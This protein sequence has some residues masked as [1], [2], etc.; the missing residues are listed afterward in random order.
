M[1]YVESSQ[2][3]QR[4]KDSKKILLNVH[5][6]PDP[7]TVG[8]ALSMYKVLKNMGKNVDIVCPNEVP[9]ELSF[10]ANAGIIKK[11]NFNKFSFEDYDLFIIMDTS[12]VERVTG[13]SDVKN[14]P[15]TTIVID[16]HKTS[17]SFGDINLMDLSTSSVCEMLYFLFMDWKIKIDK[18]IANCLYTGILGDTGIFQFQICP[19][20]FKVADALMSLDANHDK[21]VFNLV[22][23]RP[24][25]LLKGWGKILDSLQLEKDF[26][27]VWSA[28]DYNTFARLG[29]VHGIRDISATLFL[30]TVEDTNFGLVMVEEE[31]G[32]LSVSLR[33]RNNFD[34]SKIAQSLGGG[35]HKAAA[36]A[37]VRD[38]SFGKAKEKVLFV[39]RE[40]A[41][42]FK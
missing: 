28:M 15:L 41:K 36:A 33:A 13:T 21:I 19:N 39:A 11:T 37:K 25:N 6:E 8:C 22:N 38:L 10:L 30:R 42:N 35:G 20:T 2:I 3:L 31:R 4:I 40:Y 17:D 12:R 34:I 16:N 9:I 23:R 24:L 26:R 18:D 5:I 7:D 27:F 1:K 29:K 14:L 32:V